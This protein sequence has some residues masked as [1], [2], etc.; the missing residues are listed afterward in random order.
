MGEAPSERPPHLGLRWL[1]S[2]TPL[3][4]VHATEEAVGGVGKERLAA[5]QG[6]GRGGG[7]GWPGPPGYLLGALSNRAD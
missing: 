3:R 4:S 7:E 5:V 1:A 2:P 6:G